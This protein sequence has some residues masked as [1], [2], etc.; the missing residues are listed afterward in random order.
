MSQTRLTVVLSQ[1]P[2]KHPA[3]RGLE[4]A[5]AAALLVEPGIEAGERARA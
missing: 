5:V 3:K 2:G 4:E 1:A